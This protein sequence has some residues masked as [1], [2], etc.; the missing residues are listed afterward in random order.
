MLVLAHG[1]LAL[2]RRVARAPERFVRR[3]IGGA[4]DQAALA[5]LHFEV[6]TQAEQADAIRQL[7]AG[8]MSEHGMAHATGLAVE[9][10]RGILADGGE[11]RLGSRNYPA[12]R[13]RELAEKYDQVDVERECD[14]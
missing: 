11:V 9:Q 6:L 3:R 2:G 7:A 12:W 4:L 8:G 10:I 13:V 1:D 5:R 14:A